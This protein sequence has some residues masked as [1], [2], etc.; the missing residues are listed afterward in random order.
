MAHGYKEVFASSTMRIPFGYTKVALQAV[1]IE[2]S[3][4]D[5]VSKFSGSQHEFNALDD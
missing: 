3:N 4:G 2:L 5:G 1:D